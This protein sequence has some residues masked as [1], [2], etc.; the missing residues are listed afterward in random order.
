M[1]QKRTLAILGSTGSIGTQAL[2]I[3]RENSDLYEVDLL[4]ANNNTDLLIRQAIEF[5]VNTVIIS[6]PDHYKTVFEALNPH[7][8]KVFAG[9]DSLVDYLLSSNNIDMV[10]TAMVGFSGL[11]PTI[12]A[13]KSGKAIAL[14]NKETLVAAGQLIMELAH[15][16]KTP[17]IPVDS[18]HSAIFQCLLGESSEIKKITLT[19]S[20]GPFLNHCINDFKNISVEDA[21]KHPNWDMGAKISIDSATMMNKG[22]EMIEARWLFGIHQSKI[23][24]IV[25]P[26]SIIHSLVEFIDNSTKA[27]M[28]SPDM[29]LPIQYALSYPNRLKSL[30]S[31]INLAKIGNLSFHSPDFNK[32]PC[33][34]IAYQA[35]N[36][37]G[38]MPCIM[39]A[40]NEIS[41]DF[42]IKG[43]IS[44]DKIP[45]LI[46][47][48]MKRCTFTEFPTIEDI[49]IT[50]NEAR[51]IASDLIF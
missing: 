47:K 8:I 27:Q 40:A 34:N 22:L 19:A 36:Q 3:I 46:E 10:L 21:L 50:N 33:A 5:E 43:K 17:I 12:A 28:G 41:V 44:F 31:S 20:G 6:N 35:I 14:A 45:T 11:K 29:K 24:I 25:H 15:K 4:T 9:E 42:F 32:F 23:D 37:G 7:Y 18:E 1:I 51:N 16:Y 48:T 26:Q 2:E 49:L 30:S 38:N 13:I 39:N